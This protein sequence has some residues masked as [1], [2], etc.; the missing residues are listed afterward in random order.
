MLETIKVETPDHSATVDIT[1][2]ISRKVKDSAVRNGFCVVYVPHTTAGIMINEGADPDVMDDVLTTLDKLAPWRGG[3]KH[4]EGNSAAHIK[5]IL[6]GGSV[7]I[8]IDD[9][10]LKLGTWERVFLCEFDGPRTRQ[11]HIKIISG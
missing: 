10:R 8:I 7:Q 2:F 11:I 6:V 3:Y 5:A 9:G 4:A 1:D